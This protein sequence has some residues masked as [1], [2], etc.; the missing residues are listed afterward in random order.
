MDGWQSKTNGIPDLIREIHNIFGED[1]FDLT[2]FWDDDNTA[3]GIKKKDK[4]IYIAGYENENNGFNYYI[5]LELIDEI[6]FETLRMI[7]S[8]HEATLTQAIG[9][10]LA[11][12]TNDSPGIAPS[13]K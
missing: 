10:I 13:S 7:K 4:L 2:D 8:D 12:I 11:L 3:I 5:E 1:F 6:S 9:H